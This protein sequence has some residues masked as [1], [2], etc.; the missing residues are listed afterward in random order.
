DQPDNF[1]ANRKSLLA[2]ANGCNGPIATAI[3]AKTLPAGRIRLPATQMRCDRCKNAATDSRQSPRTQKLVPS[4]KTNPPTEKRLGTTQ[5]FFPPTKRRCFQRRCV[6]INA[7]T[8]VTHRSQLGSTQNASRQV[9]TKFSFAS[10][11]ALIGDDA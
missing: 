4:T 9:L 3:D 1:P 11:A 8:V 6:A 5:R 10:H 7:K 2:P